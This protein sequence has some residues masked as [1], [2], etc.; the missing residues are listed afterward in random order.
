MRKETEFLCVLEPGDTLARYDF[1]IDV[2]DQWDSNRHSAEY[3]F[4]Q[5]GDKNQFGGLFFYDSGEAAKTVLCVACKNYKRNHSQEVHYATVTTCKVVSEI[6]LLDLD[7]GVPLGSYDCPA[8]LTRLLGGGIDI[9]TPEFYN[10]QNKKDFSVLRDSIELNG[11]IANSRSTIEDFFFYLPPFLT[12]HISDFNNGKVLK[13]LLIKQGYEG[14]RFV[15]DQVSDTY[16]L[17]DSTK[18]TGPKQLRINVLNEY[19]GIYD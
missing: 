1:G 15:E 9:L 3:T 19:P 7:L 16:C 6:R 13:D 14:Y 10:Y 2:P 12:Q 8:L 17:L 11:G 5:F 4:P 18:I